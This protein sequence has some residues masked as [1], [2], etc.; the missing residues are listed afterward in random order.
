LL[1]IYV[2]KSLHTHFFPNASDVLEN[3]TLKVITS[4]SPMKVIMSVSPM[5]EIAAGL[6]GM[7][8]TALQQ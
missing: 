6:F 7:T 8:T 2:N 4:G 3:K 5:K 1:S